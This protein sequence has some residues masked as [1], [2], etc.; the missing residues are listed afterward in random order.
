MDVGSGSGAC[1]IAAMISGALMSVANDIDVAA[2][3]SALINADLNSVLLKTSWKNLIG[4][5]DLPFDCILLGDVF[6]DVEIADQLIPWLH[7]MKKEG[8]EI[9]IG[10]PG[11][12][13][14]DMEKI[15]NLKLKASYESENVCIENHGFKRV[16]V[17]E[18]V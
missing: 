8:K 16:F 11:R 7:S 13:A 17:W 1:S 14:L 18:F 3:E 2:S 6:Y 9:F 5:R 4:E 15:T 10:D 12:H